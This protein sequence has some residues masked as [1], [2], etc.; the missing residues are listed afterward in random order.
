MKKKYK[1]IIKENISAL[2]SIKILSPKRMKL[3]EINY[4]K[5]IMEDA[6][7]FSLIDPAITK[8]IK[9]GFQISISLLKRNHPFYKKL[10][11]LIRFRASE[12]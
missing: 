10:V 12:K 3:E 8:E 2:R 11:S 7:L 9:T 5:G 4:N 1:T 6:E